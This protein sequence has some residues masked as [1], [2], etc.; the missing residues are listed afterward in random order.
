MENLYK[1][2]STTLITIGDKKRKGKSK[3]I[4][5]YNRNVKNALS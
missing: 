3:S 5:N 2:I 4:F 1:N